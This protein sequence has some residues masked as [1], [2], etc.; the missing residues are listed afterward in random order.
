MGS[1]Y[2]LFAYHAKL[3]FLSFLVVQANFF[4]FGFCYPS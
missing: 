4:T 2:V 3:L 1:Q